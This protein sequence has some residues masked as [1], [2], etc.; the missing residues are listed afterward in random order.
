M[1]KQVSMMKRHPDLTMEAFVERYETHHARLGEA[2]FAKAKRFLRR[3][4]QPQ[5]NPLTGETTE[6]DFDVVMEIWWA[7]RADFEDAM[8]ALASNPE[9]VAQA[10]ESG[11]T[12]FASASNPAF[13][14]IERDSDMGTDWAA[15]EA[16][17]S[18]R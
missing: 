3:Y 18:A 11:R 12:L 13:T 1:L 2:L 9:A 14:V 15:I 16:G 6:L 10:S 5:T 7:S 4:V 17:G 8:A